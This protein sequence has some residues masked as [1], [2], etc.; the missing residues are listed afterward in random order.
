[1][2]V[3][4]RPGSEVYSYDFRYRGHRFSGSTGCTTKREAQKHEAELKRQIRARAADIGAPMTFLTASTLWW[5]EK[6]R[7]RADAIDQERYL[8][9][10]QEVIGRKT[11]IRDIS[12]ADIA[13][14]VAK[15]RG[16][17]VE[18]RDRRGRLTRPPHLPSNATVNQAVTKPMRAILR[19]ARHIWKQRVQD[20]AWRE[21]LLPEA[22]ERVREASAEEEA[23]AM[24]AIREDYAPALRFAFLTGC[25]RAEI[26]GLEWPHVDFF[27]R[28]FTVTGKGARSRTLPMTEEIF[29]LLWALKDDHPTAVFTYVCRR[30]RGKQV[31][32]QRYPITMEGFK[33]AWRRA[34]DRTDLHDFRFHDTRHTAATRLVRATG[35]LKL[36][37]KLLGHTEIATTN[38]YAHV[39]RDDL[40]AGLSAAH[41]AAKSPTE[42]STPSEEEAAKPLRKK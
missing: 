28:E 10:L 2:S 42:I 11:L 9:W 38:R 17:P 7:F 31:K 35:N 5:E 39:T 30:P 26:V 29:R 22:Q 34:R 36:A 3:Y 33:T 24:V 37:Q 13:R 8:A 20:I 12:D 25:R 40:R 6:G 32:G 23:K 15:R 18:F 4:K 14:A 1:M 27:N 41:A 16:E 19:R 21:H